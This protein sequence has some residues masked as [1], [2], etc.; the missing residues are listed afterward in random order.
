LKLARAA[1]PAGAGELLTG[2]LCCEQQAKGG[3]TGK[4]AL[5]VLACGAWCWVTGLWVLR[6]AFLIVYGMF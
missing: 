5:G 6:V 1:D 2:L 4:S 3:D